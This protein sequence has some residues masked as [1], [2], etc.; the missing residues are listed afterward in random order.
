M[1]TNPAR[2]QTSAPKTRAQLLQD[3]V[4]GRL[5]DADGRFG[6]FGGC[7]VPE[8]LMPAVQRLTEGVY[9]LLPQESFRQRLT[10]ELRDWVGAADGAYTGPGAV[11]QV[12]RRSVVQAR[13][14]RAHGR[15][16]DQ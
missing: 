16:Q 13:G 10:E 2:L 11:G 6:P 7:Y 14:S 1:S 5:P 12:G 15:S 9:R 3:L 8:T 4:A